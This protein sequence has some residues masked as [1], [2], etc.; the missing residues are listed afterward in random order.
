MDTKRTI[1]GRTVE[2]IR[3]LLKA[4]LPK[5]AVAI[6]DY[7]GVAYIKADAILERLDEV[8]GF[9][10]TVDFPVN[11]AAMS[12]KTL[13]YKCKCV[14]ELYDDE[15]RLVTSR[16][17][18]GGSDVIF[19]N[20]K[21]VSADGKKVDVKDARGQSIPLDYT[22][23]TANT[24]TAAATDAL[25]KL[26]FR[27]FGIGKSDLEKLEESGYDE[28]KVIASRSY[29]DNIFGELTDATGNS[30]KF[31]CFKS[32]MAQLKL[33][34]DTFKVGSILEVKMSDS[35]DNKGNPQKKI[36]KVLTSNSSAPS[37]QSTTNN[38]TSTPQPQTAKY[39]VVLKAPCLQLQNGAGVLYNGIEKNT[40]E[41]VQLVYLDKEL[42]AMNLD[43]NKVIGYSD[44]AE[45]SVKAY[46]SGIANNIKQLVAVA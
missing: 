22:D 45:V 3:S 42:A 32:T 1:N 4:P 12:G 5:E 25:K 19:A 2:E 11:E 16:A 37:N 15:D 39:N 10:Y 31:V 29:N 7:D 17:M 34:P 36:N 44:N 20:E 9:N 28:V 14:V 40:G 21:M 24:L 43:R 33:T 41:A 18:W 13:T 26:A 46:V 35:T 6:R 8:L 38:T 27:Y 30:H 23:S